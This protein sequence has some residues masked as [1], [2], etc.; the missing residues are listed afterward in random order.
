M[1]AGYGRVTG[2]EARDGAMAMGRSLAANSMI[3]LI[4]FQ[5][6]G[7]RRGACEARKRADPAARRYFNYAPMRGTNRARDVTEKLRCTTIKAAAIFQ[8]GTLGRRCRLYDCASADQ[9]KDR[10]CDR[11][12]VCDNKDEKERKREREMCVP[13][14]SR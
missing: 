6:G 14:S 1:R 3:K 13:L 7:P 12:A 2:I 4:R 9:F 11:F 5:L 8:V 10:A